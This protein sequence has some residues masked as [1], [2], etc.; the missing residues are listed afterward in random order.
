VF[1][2]GLLVLYCTYPAGDGPEW[3]WRIELDT[4]EAEQCT[5]R[6][7]NLQPEEPTASGG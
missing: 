7:Y 2:A 3:G 1:D 4:S 5:L 6:M